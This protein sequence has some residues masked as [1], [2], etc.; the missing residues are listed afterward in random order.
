METIYEISGLNKYYGKF[1]AL[2]NVNLQI[3][4]GKIIGL[5]GRNGAGKST[6]LRS[7]LGLLRYEGGISYRGDDIKTMKHHLFEDVAFI[8]DVN[9]IDDRLTVQQVIEYVRGVNKHWNEE[10]FMSLMEK[11]NLPLEKKISKL[12]KGMKTK[13]YLLITL[14]LET[15]MLLLDEP[16]LGLDIAFRK[17]FLNTI[18]GEYFDEE[19]SIIISTHQVEE[20]EQ[21]LQE[22]IFIDEGKIILHEDV[23]DLKNRYN[24]VTVTADQQSVLLEKGARQITHT[25]GQY[26]GILPSEIK[27]EGA[28]YHRPG[29]AD[30]FL[31]FTGGSHE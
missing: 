15:Q 4:S 30:L 28:S 7:M 13:L 6:L 1:Q 26:H 9:I 11:S 21:I 10:K 29:L 2:D 17:E 20:V 18:L 3:N 31:A 5:L 24:L 27:I 23:E 22:V 14:S 16:T 25:L 19:K 12:S 8:P